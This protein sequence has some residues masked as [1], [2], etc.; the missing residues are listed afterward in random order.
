[1]KSPA[2]IDWVFLRWLE[3]RADELD[4]LSS[5][6]GTTRRRVS[7]P[8]VKGA[9][10]S[11]ET[12]NA[13]PT[14]DHRDPVMRIELREEFFHAPHRIYREIQILLGAPVHLR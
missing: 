1:M 2:A 6:L 10:G 11:P 3:L 8:Y 9:L 4:T 13:H 7:K 14:F 5:L 12:K